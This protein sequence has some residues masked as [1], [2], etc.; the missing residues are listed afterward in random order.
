[1]RI[2]QLSIVNYRNFPKLELDLKP[3]GAIVYG[4]NGSGKTNLLES[5]AYS[6]FGRSFLNLHDKDLISFDQNLFR[7]TAQFTFLNKTLLIDSA[8]SKDLKKVR[9][10]DSR[11][12]K[13]SELF[14]YVKVVYFSPRDIDFSAGNPGFR[15]QFFDLAISQNS[16]YYMEKL[17]EYN[18]ILKQRNALLK[19][20]FDQKEKESWDKNFVRAGC[21]IIKQRLKYLQEFIPKLSKY[22]SFI[23]NKKEV[24][25]YKYVFSFPVENN[26][27]SAG[28]SRFLEVNENKE[29]LNQ[30]SLCGPHL[31][32]Y[33]F[34]N[35]G[36]SFKKF[37]S[38]G[39]KRS[40]AISARLVQ[41]NLI[42]N[43]IGDYPI[44][45]FDD[46]LAD[47]DAERTARILDLLKDDHQ[48]FIATPN[49][50]H[51]NVP[52]FP[53]IDVEKL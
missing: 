24:L 42:T 36:R 15:R 34:M 27:I 20:K 25:S 37:G 5:I 19:T 17:K 16:F 33:Y 2:D 52:G 46:V 10:N 18:R 53:R 41:A 47:L 3:T 44:L 21:E 38:Q 22:Q 29:I 9:I 1:V 30:R 4:K 13:L 50:N 26:E 23:S 48:I 40:L 32:D 11:I 12:A 31:D 51:Y 6:A 14:K 45:M 28:F 39:Q 8:Y 7:I 43:S 49:I 35:E